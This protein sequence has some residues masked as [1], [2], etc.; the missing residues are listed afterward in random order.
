[1]SIWFVAMVYGR[2]TE[3]RQIQPKCTTAWAVLQPLPPLLS[4]LL[5]SASAGQ[6]LWPASV[7]QGAPWSPHPTGGAGEVTPKAKAAPRV[8]K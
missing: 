8:P 1:M 3:K 7:L 4:L 6:K 5:P 2:C